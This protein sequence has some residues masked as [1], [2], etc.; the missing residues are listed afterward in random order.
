EKTKYTNEDIDQKGNRNTSGRKMTTPSEQNMTI[1]NPPPPKYINT[2]GTGR[3][4]NQLQ[5]LQRVVIK[6]MWK[7]NFSWPFH[8]P[9][10]AAGLNLPDYYNIIKK[11]MDLTTIQKRLEHN[12][13]TCAAECIENFK[14]MFANCYLYNKY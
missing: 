8:Q 13:Y 10:D 11:P 9:V 2:Q 4:T 6:A 3:L 12:Y 14:T 5:Y 1:V 7:H